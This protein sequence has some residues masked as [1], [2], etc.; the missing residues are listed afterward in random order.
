MS[1]MLVTSITTWLSLTTEGIGRLPVK[2]I[3]RLGGE[4]EAGN[5]LSLGDDEN[6]VNWN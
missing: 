5:A 3:V 1:R 6:K 4:S 2:R